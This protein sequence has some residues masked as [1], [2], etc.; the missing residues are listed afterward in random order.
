LGCIPDDALPSIIGVANRMDLFDRRNNTLLVTCIVTISMIIGTAPPFAL[1]ALGP[2]VVD[3]FDLTRAQFGALTTV[4]F[5]VAAILSFSAGGSADASKP[6]RVCG[7]LS[8]A[9]VVAL[10]GAGISTSY[11]VLLAFVSLAGIGQ[12]LANPLT[13]RLIAEHINRERQG[14]VTGIKQ[15]GVHIGALLTG[16]TLPWIATVFGWRGALI[17]SSLLLA[18]TWL[19]VVTRIPEKSAASLSRAGA[20]PP[21]VGASSAGSAVVGLAVYAFVMG[22]AFAC[23]GAYLPLYAHDTLGL[24]TTAAGAVL[25]AMGAVG[26]AS[27]I[28]VGYLADRLTRLPLILGALAFTA[29]AAAG[30]LLAAAHEQPGLL[31]IS[32]LLLGVSAG[33][34]S[35]VMTA[36][37]K[38]TSNHAIGRASGQVMTGFFTGFI[39]APLGFGITVDITGS[40]AVSW[41]AL[42]ILLAS[43]S[44]VMIGWDRYARAAATGTAPK[45]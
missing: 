24:S 26:V 7:L 16:L 20:A 35:V 41:S 2:L 9:S 5:S 33:W 32:A 34:N 10:A 39:V 23:A 25:G 27:R 36:V 12:A 8:V 31:W 18:V 40:Y 30:L 43:T 15:S 42:G 19:A 11:A 45:P 29:G 22:S 17:C 37:V 3:D 21:R 6:R 14:L 28:A 13:N 4:V 1:A 38:R 44:L